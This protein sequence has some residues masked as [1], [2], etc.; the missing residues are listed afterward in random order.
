VAAFFLTFSLFLQ[1]GLGF[2]ALHSGLTTIPFS[3]GTAVASAVSVRLAPRLGRSI[4]SLGCLL[5]VAG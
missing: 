3:V 2:T 1:I 4:L 5:L